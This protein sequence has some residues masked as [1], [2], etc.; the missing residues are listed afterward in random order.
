MRCN[1][2][3]AQ[4]TC[5][6]CELSQGTTG[7]SIATW[8]KGQ[9]ERFV[10]AFQRFLRWKEAN[11]FSK[12]K[13]E[14]KEENGR[15][16]KQRTQ[17]NFYYKFDQTYILWWVTPVHILYVCSM[18]YNIAQCF[19]FFGISTTPN[20]TTG[21]MPAEIFLNRRFKTRLD[22]MRPDQLQVRHQLCISKMIYPRI[23]YRHRW[24]SLLR[25]RVL[26]GR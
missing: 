7:C 26:P 14:D 18:R 4:S 13:V 20:G 1:V 16:A 17:R 9:A 23:I 12:V 10:Q 3:L 6:F 15:L 8:L 25:Y 2:A 11:R 22:L 24:L 21:Q 19:F 5:E